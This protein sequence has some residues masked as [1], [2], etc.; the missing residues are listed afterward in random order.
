MLYVTDAGQLWHFDMVFAAAE[1]VGFVPD[2]ASLE[3]A[4][5]GLVQGE[6]GK[7]YVTRSGD[8]V[9]RM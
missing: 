2:D 9:R 5:F 1:K 8:T 3:H 6:D 4:P 7:K